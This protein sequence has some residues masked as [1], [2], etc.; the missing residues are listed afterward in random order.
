M[1]VYPFIDAEKQGDH[2]DK[3]A[4]ELLRASRSAYYVD[5]AGGPPRVRNAAPS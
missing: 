3:R 1:N 5:R 4:C 2:N